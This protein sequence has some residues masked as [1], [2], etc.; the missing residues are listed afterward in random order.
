MNRRILTAIV[1][2]LAAGLGCRAMVNYQ[3]SAGPRYAAPLPA[4]S[5]IE[6]YASVNVGTLRVVTYNVKYAHRVDGAIYALRHY[7]PLR[8]ADII[9]LQEMDAPATHQ[10][11]EALAM[12]YVYYPAGI[13]GHTHRD[14]GNAILSRWPITADE[15]LLLPHLGRIR[16]EQRIATVANVQIG[17]H[18]VRVYCL[19]LGTPSEIGWA[20]RRDQAHMV[21]EDAAKYRLAI[22]GGDMNS[23][24]IGKEFRNAGF[25]WPTEHDSFTTAIFNWDHIFLKGFGSPFK[26][27]GVARDTLGV[28]DHF[29]VWAL[30]TLNP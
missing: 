14:F 9:L 1:L 23:H 28:S 6:P 19:H 7:G 21:V 15:K 29:P 22:V 4:P 11:A 10:I 27:A 5:T 13:D 3:S 12:A 30:A 25:V 26:G 24:G 2:T 17:T 8:G 20:K 18:T 16:H